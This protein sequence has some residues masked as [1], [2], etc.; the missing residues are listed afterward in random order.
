MCLNKIIRKIILLNLRTFCINRGR[1]GLRANGIMKFLELRKPNNAAKKKNCIIVK[2]ENLNS[3][4]ISKKSIRN[5]SL[6][7]QS[8]LIHV[9]NAI[10]LPEESNKPRYWVFFESKF[11]KK[12]FRKAL[13][14]APWKWFNFVQ[15][16]HF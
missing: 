13:A 5:N 3:S 11:I 4:K 15:K 9:W 1:T 7:Q 14:E 8:Y 6:S 16:F 12:R 10:Y 2:L